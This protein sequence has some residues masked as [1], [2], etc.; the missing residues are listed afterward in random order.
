MTSAK[1]SISRLALILKAKGIKNVV[2]SPGSR[3]APLIISVANDPYFTCYNIPDERSAAFFALGIGLSTRRP[4]VICCTSGSAAINYGPAISEAYY[5]KIPLIALTADRPEEWIDQRAGQTIRQTDLYRNYIKFS[6]QLKQEVDNH[7]DLWYNDRLIN[8]AIE[9][10]TSDGDG[11]VHINVPLREPL[12]D[13][14]ESH[15]KKPKIIAKSKTHASL[16]DSRIQELRDQFDRHD[17]VLVICGQHHPDQKWADAIARLSKVSSVVVLTELTSNVYGDNIISCI[18]RTIN[19]IEDLDV[20]G[21]KPSLLIT[22]GYSLVSK[23]IRFLLRDMDILQHWHVDADDEFI[24][25][26]MSLTDIIPVR[27]D[28]FVEQIIQRTDSLKKPYKERWFHLDQYKKEKH[29]EY[30]DSAP[31]SDLQVVD[32]V[33]NALPDHTHVHM[34]NSTSVRYAQLF[35]VNETFT[36]QC[37]RG[38]SGIDGCSSTGVGY[39]ICND[40]LNVLIT[41]DLAFFYDANAFW[42]AYVPANFRVLILNNHGGNIF[43]VIKGP[44]TTDHLDTHF[45]AHHKTKA[46]GIALA[47]NLTYLSADDVNSLEQGLTQFLGASDQPIIFEVFTPRLENDKILKAYF[48][49]IRMR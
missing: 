12:Y 13:Q 15:T 41:G 37:N 14:V 3:N 47:H 17:K 18:D 48:E 29:R 6:T 30:L 4:V 43:R 25:T 33:M 38:V 19:N 32:Q 39:A 5:Q 16:S 49:H 27:I 34:A 20:E 11:P 31:W 21:Y 24:D 9:T 42:N 22:C 7:D 8:Q 40:E 10:A 36:F 26:Y 44:A 35:D 23:K 28:Y 45:E 1:E 2:F 46:K